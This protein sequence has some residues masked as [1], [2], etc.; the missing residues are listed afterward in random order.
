MFHWPPRPPS[1]LGGPWP[2]GFIPSPPV[3]LSLPL[4]I[5]RREKTCSLLPGLEP[6]N[7]R[8]SGCWSHQSCNWCTADNT[9]RNIEEKR[10]PRSPPPGARP[11]ELLYFCCCRTRKAQKRF[12]RGYPYF[13]EHTPLSC[14]L[15][16]VRA[17]IV[18]FSRSSTA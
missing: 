10:L 12:G 9:N 16:C 1:F 5:P 18:D 11:A 2:Q 7:S 3:V 14:M 13:R 4:A 8:Q 15:C 6:P 17:C